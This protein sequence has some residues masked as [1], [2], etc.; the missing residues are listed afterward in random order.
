MES[1]K[2]EEQVQRMQN[3]TDGG[4]FADSRNK[5]RAKSLREEY[6]SECTLHTKPQ[7]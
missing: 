5:L 4:V 3:G 2:K 1:S 7:K 6:L